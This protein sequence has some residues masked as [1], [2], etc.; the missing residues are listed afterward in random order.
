MKSNYQVGETGTVQNANLPRFFGIDF[1]CGAGGMTCGLIRAGGYVRAGIDN[2]PACE[3]T[4][5]TNNRNRCLDGA[6]PEYI[7]MDVLP[8]EEDHPTGQQMELRSRLARVL[9]DLR[10][11]APGIP[12]LFS[13]CA[14]CQPFTKIARATMSQGRTERRARDRVL[15]LEAARFVEWFRP[16]IVLSENVS[17]IRS[18]RY[19]DVWQKFESEL[20][21]LGYVFGSRVVCASNFGIPQFR[22]RSILVGIRS[23][24]TSSKVR[25]SG[26]IALPDRDRDA[27]PTTVSQALGHLPA[28]QAGQSDPRTPNHRCR[29]LTEVNLRRLN[30][31][32]P[33]G[34]NKSL[35]TSRFGDL[36][37]RCHTS[38]VQR[39]NVSGFSDVYSRMHPDKPAPTITTRCHS[40]SN[41][42]FGHYD[43]AQVRGIT[44]REAALLQSF[45]EDYVFYPTDVIERA[46]RM[47]GNAVPPTLAAFFANFALECIEGTES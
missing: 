33:G 10:N 41:G 20:S 43:P 1:F 14:P 8:V 34:S 47:V 32:E 15:L 26:R 39:T 40:I 18:S 23:D 38:L 42:R 44:P 36:S 31:I 28:L 24:R 17:G 2:D 25:E 22:K 6:A 37:L 46:A 19:G 45:P 30:A 35:K 13:F 16:E 29:S 9:E 11:P 12:L 5:V 27:R 7:R 3:L 21:G 4:F